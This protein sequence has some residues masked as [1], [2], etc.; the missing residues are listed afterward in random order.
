MKKKRHVKKY[1]LKK[2]YKKLLIKKIEQQ[3]KHD[4][5]LITKED[6]NHLSLNL[7]KLSKDDHLFSSD[8]AT[9][10][11][12]YKLIEEGYANSAL[13]LMNCIN[14]SDDHLVHDTSILPALYCFRHYLE[15]TIKQTLTEYGVELKETHNLS[16]LFEKL[17]KHIEENEETKIIK[18]LIHELTDVDCGGCSFRYNRS[19]KSPTSKE[20]DRTIDVDT[21]RIRLLQLYSFF[22]GILEEITVAK[23]ENY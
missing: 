10:I 15:L 2:K 1:Q 23:E 13:F 3:V 4:F 6:I 8:N 19:L 21:L 5:Y 22:Y 14:I 18:K 16:A 11:P 9:S 12:M 17:L 7:P 20:F